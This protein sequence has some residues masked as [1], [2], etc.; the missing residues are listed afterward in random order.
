VVCGT[1]GLGS[2]LAR[3]F[4]AL[5]QAA[6]RWICDD[7]P[8]VASV[9]YGPATRWT[10][11]YDDLLADEDLDAIAFA[12]GEL[13]AGGRTL[14]AVAADKH[15]LVDGPLAPTAAQA[16]ELVAAAAWRNRRAMAHF[17]CLLRPGVRRLDRLIGRGALGEVF[18]VH[19]R[20]FV[21]RGE[22]P[23]DLLRG[24]GAETLAVVLDL[25]G[26]EPVEA[27]ARGDAHLGRGSADVVHAQLGFATGID[28]H[29]HLSCLEGERLER[30]SVVGSQAT[31]V[32][33]SR[34]AEHEL[35]LHVTSPS[36]GLFDDVSVEEGG[37]VAFR[38]PAGDALR[39]GCARFL[40]AVRS[41][42]DLPYGREASASLAVLEALERSCAGGGSPESIAPK[43]GRS[44]HNVVAF[45]GT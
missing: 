43:L 18:Y 28:V 5:P 39:E 40:T 44:E 26:D 22:A 30:I 29:L 10:R 9:G 14:A 24:P 27:V 4:D 3:A 45:P 17:P 31:A 19:A 11:D 25:L 7:A 23:V 21:L 38:L 42:G 32:L 8:R 16:D 37:R 15:V 6:L 1:G 20:H 36:P 35:S 2:E 34:D 12:S 13:A 33:D 41:R